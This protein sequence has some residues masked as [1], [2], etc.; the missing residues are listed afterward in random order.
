MS[1]VKWSDDYKIGDEQI[2]KEHWGLFA[3]VQDLA[4]K[5]EQ[6]AS[7]S[8]TAATLE[9]L[10]DYVNIHFEHEEGLMLESLYPGLE[11][12]KRAHEGLEHLVELTLDDYRRAP[13]NFDHEV[14]MEFLSN[15]L[16]K[17]ILVVDMEFAAYYKNWLKN[18][19]PP[20]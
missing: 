8:S 16:A 4:D 19:P 12:H 14:L 10:V 7:E 2:D 9:A 15:W 17:H 20:A 11:A 18:A 6:G 1:I 3:L 5:R 13:E